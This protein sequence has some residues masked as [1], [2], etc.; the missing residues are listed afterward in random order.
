MYS[1]GA[2]GKE[3][4]AIGK[5]VGGNT[6]KIHRVV[7][8]YGLRIEFDLTGGEVQDSKAAPEL[9]VRLALAGSMI[10]DKSY[11]KLKRNYPLNAGNGTLYVGS[12]S[13]RIKRVWEHKNKVIPSRFTAQY[14]VHMLV[15]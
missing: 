14:N 7:D 2:V 11:D 3:N 8:A 6:T 10:A 1:A 15:Y 4:Q 13:D 12:T 5:S 9:I